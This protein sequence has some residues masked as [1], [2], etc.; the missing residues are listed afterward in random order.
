MCSH[1]RR[2]VSAP[3]QRTLWRWMGPFPPAYCST[4]CASI[5]HADTYNNSQ[6]SVG[7]IGRI[8]EAFQS[9]ARHF[10]YQSPM[11]HPHACIKYNTKSCSLQKG[12]ILYC[13][14]F[15]NILT[16]FC[17]CIRQYVVVHK[18][19]HKV[20]SPVFCRQLGQ[21][22]CLLSHHRQSP[23]LL[24]SRFPLFPHSHPLCLLVSSLHQYST[25]LSFTLI[26]LLSIQTFFTCSTM[27]PQNEEDNKRNTQHRDMHL[28][29]KIYNASYILS[30][31]STDL[32]PTVSSMFPHL[33]LRWLLFLVSIY[34]E[35][36]DYNVDWLRCDKQSWFDKYLCKQQCLLWGDGG[37]PLENTSH[38]H[39]LA[40]MYSQ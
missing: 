36:L 40:I 3:V 28:S 15:Q 31:I 25:H 16:L 18:I 17:L 24:W 38:P 11:S 39:G 10:I 1:C 12:I 29:L 37:L 23:T 26:S 27:M 13:T 32:P 33:L 35:C 20:V 8:K 2:L 5:E 9:H 21:L 22:P 7:A 4:T 6:N 19:H 14:L 34:V 30:Y